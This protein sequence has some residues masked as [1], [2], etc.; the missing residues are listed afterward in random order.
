MPEAAAVAKLVRQAALLMRTGKGREGNVQPI[1]ADDLLVGGD[2]HGHVPNFKRLVALADLPNHPRRHLVL[3]EFVHG[4]GRYAN[5]G[6]TSHQVLDLACNLKCRHPHQV[7]LLPGN[8]ELSELT[9][10]SIAKNGVYLNELFAQGLASQYGDGAGEVYD[11]YHE[12]FR[13]MPLAVRTKNRI[14]CVHTTPSVKSLDG[15][16]RNVFTRFGLMMD[17][18]ERGGSLYAVLWDRDLSEEASRRFAELMDVD[19]LATGH[20]PLENGFDRPNPRRVIVDCCGEPAGYALFPADRPLDADEFA[21]C[22]R[23]LPLD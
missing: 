9:G 23:H 15:F 5:G 7:H 4:P 8:H 12:L 14:L 20:I 13:S 19:W 16:D 11:A 3:Q 22:L 10:R 18:A 17:Q 2:L 21:A 6:D 1:D